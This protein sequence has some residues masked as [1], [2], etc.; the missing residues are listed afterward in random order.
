MKDVT[1]DIDFRECK[2]NGFTSDSYAE[3]IMNF[4]PEYNI[5]F[6]LVDSPLSGRS[7]FAFTRISGQLS[8]DEVTH[9]ESTLKK[10]FESIT[11]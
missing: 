3:K 4:L 10:A 7:L 6:N 2:A 9:I 5:K 11:A 1:I 8:A